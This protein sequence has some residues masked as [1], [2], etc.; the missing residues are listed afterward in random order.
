MI[1]WEEGREKKIK[2]KNGEDIMK[3]NSGNKSLLESSYVS[4]IGSALKERKL[5]VI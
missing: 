5:I 2:I 3:D 4:N 1:E